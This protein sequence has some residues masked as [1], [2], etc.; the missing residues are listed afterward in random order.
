MFGG[1]EVSKSLKLISSKKL[2]FLKVTPTFDNIFWYLGFT[3]L[4]HINA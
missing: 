3:G 4:E 1:R 2:I